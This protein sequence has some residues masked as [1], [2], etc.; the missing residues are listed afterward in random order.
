MITHQLL[1]LVL[2]QGV[3]SINFLAWLFECVTMVHKHESLEK[4]FRKRET[5]PD[6]L[7]FPANTEV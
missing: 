4:A 3:V 2:D 1:V 6:S 7:D 5:I